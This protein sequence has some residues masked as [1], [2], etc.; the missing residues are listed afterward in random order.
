MT[1]RRFIM[2]IKHTL[3]IPVFIFLLIAG[4]KKDKIPPQVIET[5]PPNG[6][7]DVDPSITEISVTFNEPM[8]D[9]SWSWCHEGGKDFPNTTGKP[10]YTDSLTKNV[11]PVSLKPNT[12]YTIWI[13]LD[14]FNNFKDE[15]ENPVKPYLFTFT[16]GKIEQ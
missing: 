10:H 6:A 5:N 11:L 7:T 4:C 9:N 1:N 15:S 2:S 16:T 8:M 3:I 14:N 12:K 13:N